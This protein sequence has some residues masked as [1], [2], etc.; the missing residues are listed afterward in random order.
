MDAL[1]HAQILAMDGLTEKFAIGLAWFFGT[2]VI[3]QLIHGGIILPTIYGKF[4]K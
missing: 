2:N 1:L 4:A 3:A